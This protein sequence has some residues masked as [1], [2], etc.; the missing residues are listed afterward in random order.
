MAV[1]QAASNKQAAEQT[2]GVEN[3]KE[4]TETPGS[5]RPLITNNARRDHLRSQTSCRGL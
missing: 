5:Q 2:K 3:S 4:S 1:Q